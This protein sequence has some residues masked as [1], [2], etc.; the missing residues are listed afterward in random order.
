LSLQIPY[1]ENTWLN[2]IADKLNL[3]KVI[4]VS[5]K[6][7]I[8]DKELSYMQYS[9]LYYLQAHLSREKDKKICMLRIGFSK[10]IAH[11]DRFKAK[12]Y[13]GASF[14]LQHINGEF[15]EKKGISTGNFYLF[16]NSEPLKLQD[17]VEHDLQLEL[18]ALE[19][20]KYFVLIID[21]GEELLLARIKE[22]FKEYNLG[23]FSLNKEFKFKLGERKLKVYVVER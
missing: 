11:L 10:N 9:L 13:K 14:T 8:L 3:K 4:Y 22:F 23:K 18:S 15:L 19:E 1:T 5:E 17:V 7:K 21:K 6:N 12:N 2:N 16:I 20:Y